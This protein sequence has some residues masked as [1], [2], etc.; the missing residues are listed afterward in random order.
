MK[1]PKSSDNLA[2]LLRSFKDVAKEDNPWSETFVSL[3]KIILGK[4]IPSLV[5]IATLM[6]N[7]QVSRTLK[8]LPET[9]ENTPNIVSE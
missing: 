6:R 9:Q 7:K 1:Y 8:T 2:K 3:Y 5:R 4:Q